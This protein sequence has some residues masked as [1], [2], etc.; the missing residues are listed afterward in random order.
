MRSLLIQETVSDEKL[1][2]V[3]ALLNASH[4]REVFQ[5]ELAAAPGPAAIAA[6]CRVESCRIVYTK[7]RPGKNFLITYLLEVVDPRTGH[8]GRSREQLMTMLACVEGESRELFANAKK[9]PLVDTGFGDGVFQIPG[10]EAV[11]WVFPND[12]KLT[13]LPALIDSDSLKNRFLPEIVT[14]NFGDEWSIMEMESHPVHYVPERACTVRVKIGLRS[15]ANGDTAERVLFGKT[16]C[17]GEGEAAWQSLQALWG[18][19]ARRAGRLLIPQP[20]AY[21]PEIRTLWQC[22]LEGKTLNEVDANSGVFFE[23]L[24]DA[25]LAVAELHRTAVP[26]APLITTGEIIAKLEMSA[27]LLSRVLSRIGPKRRDELLAIVRRLISVSDRIGAGSIATLHGDLHLK[28]LFVTNDR[29]ALLDLDNLSR[30]DP[31]LDLGSFVALLHY[32]GLIECKS[33]YVVEEISRRFVQSY[34]ANV[35]WEVSEWALNWHIAAALI[36]E[37]AYRCVTRLKAGRLDMVDDIIELANT[38]TASNQPQR[39]RDT[40]KRKR[41]AR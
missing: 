1:P 38:F 4:M 33:H 34:R 14:G 32:R 30:G 9:A 24:E 25:G 8:T 13:G 18:S 28:N 16:Y 23:L 5:Q 17:L 20:L 31:L 19:E 10:L 15:A 35:D 7:Y 40:E 6:V 29:I 11:V 39:H 21:H 27:D 26:S 41:D 37:R 22:G 2:Q 36:Y 12:R 3:E